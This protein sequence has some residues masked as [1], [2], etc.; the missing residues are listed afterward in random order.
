[1]KSAESTPKQGKLWKCEPEVVECMIGRVSVIYGE[2]G[3][4]TLTNFRMY[5]SKKL[6]YRNVSI[7][8]WRT[9]RFSKNRSYEKPYYVKGIIKQSG[10]E[11]TPKYNK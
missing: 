6:T 11:E 1:M 7:P 5:G 9:V 3:G 10:S 2:N 8:K 4:K